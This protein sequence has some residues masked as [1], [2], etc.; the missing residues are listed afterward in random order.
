MQNTIFITENLMLFFNKIK[1][2]AKTVTFFQWNETKN[3]NVFLIR[4]DIDL[5]LIPALKIKKIEKECGVTSTFFIMVSNQSYNVMSEK[6]KKIINEI[7]NL[8]FEIGLHFDPTIYGRR[9]KEELQDKVRFEA[10]VLE[11]ITNK[12]IKSISLHK[13]SIHNN[14]Y[15]FDDFVNTYDE[16]IFSDE[17][18]LSDSSMNF[19]GKNP[20]EFIEN[21][22]KQTIQ[23]LLHPL[24]FNEKNIYYSTTFSTISTPS[25]AES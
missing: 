14:F 16:R 24:H 8:G 7:S 21:V 13:P 17:V 19:R 10:S 18:Y 9:T 3:K 6:S 1:S 15:M 12:K 23:V 20:F 2:L 22:K 11:N 5:D 4:H 25:L